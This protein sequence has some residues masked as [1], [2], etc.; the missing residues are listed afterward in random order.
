MDRSM[1][2]S[3]FSPSPGVCILMSIV[4]VMLTISSHPPLLILSSPFPASGSFLM[5][6]LFAAG[7]QSIGTSV[8]A[9]VLPMNN[10]GLI[11]FKI[12][13]FDFVVHG[14]QESFPG[15]QLEKISILQCSAFI[16]VQLSHLY[17]TTGKK[18]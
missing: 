15:P 9:S 12:D 3:H 17:M 8:S 18:K 13:W 6:Q 2:G 11:S 7:G 1:P 14:T 16:M 10:S 4:S 5:S